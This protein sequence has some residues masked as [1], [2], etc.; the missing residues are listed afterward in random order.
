MKNKFALLLV[1]CSL[2][3]V[4][5]CGKDDLE[6]AFDCTE[7]ALFIKL[8]HTT[9]AA[10]PKKIDYVIDYSGTYSVKSVKWTF[11]DGKTETV[12]GATTS[13]IYDAAGTYSV[14]AEVTIH[15][16]SSSC[17]SS[18]EKSITVD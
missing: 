1:I 7:Q 6:N 12:N 3:F 4:F 11:G 16:G 5:S 9:D 8:T 2:L 17:N 14:K 10:N 15:N 18:R 13:H